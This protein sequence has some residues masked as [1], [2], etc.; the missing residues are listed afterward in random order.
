MTHFVDGPA[1]GTRLLLGR[2]PLFLRAVRDR[3]GKWDALDQ[4]SDE[5]KI[6]EEI[7]VYRLKG[8]PCRIHAQLT[9]NGRRVCQ[10][11]EGGN[12]EVV[13]NQPPDDVL[14]ETAA[15]RTWVATQVGGIVH[16]DGSISEGEPT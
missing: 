13:A 4:L 7:V 14:R 6:D 3:N 16:E 10:W 15:Y 2:A 9:I 11:Y 1:A 8:Q 12:Y 5:P